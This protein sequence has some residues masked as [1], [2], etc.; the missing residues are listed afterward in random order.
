MLY[1]TIKAIISGVIAALVSEM[2][3]RH[4]GWGGLLA[5][6]PLTALMALVWT[7]RDTRDPAKVAALASGTFWFVLPSL[8][9]FLI[10]PGLIRVGIGVWPALAIGAAITLLLYAGFA[11]IAPR[12]G[13]AG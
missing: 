1:F 13:I 9:L 4:P 12:M 11:W 7:Y 6:L 3:R 5:S 8:P 2:A 10:A